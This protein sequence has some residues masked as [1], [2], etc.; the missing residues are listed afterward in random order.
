MKRDPE[1]QHFMS[2]FSPELIYYLFSKLEISLRKMVDYNTTTKK[3]FTK[4]PS[5][6][7]E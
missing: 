5:K 3:K 7:N 4:G 6:A 2:K 1:G